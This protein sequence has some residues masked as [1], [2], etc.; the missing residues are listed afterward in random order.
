MAS[1]KDIHVVKHNDGWATRTE[2]AQR[3]GRVYDTKQ[4]ALSGGRDQAKRKQVELVIHGRDG[5]IQNSNSFGNDPFPP[6]DEK[7]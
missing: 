3:V 5:K 1:K 2:N 7:H 4:E 6:R